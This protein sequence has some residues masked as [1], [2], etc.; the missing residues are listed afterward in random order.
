MKTWSLCTILFA[1]LM[2]GCAPDDSSNSPVGGETTSIYIYSKSPAPVDRYELEE[3]LQDFLGDDGM[4]S[5]G[6]AGDTGWNIDLE[7]ESASAEDVIQRLI[8]FLKEKQV[9]SD[10]HLDVFPPDWKEGD[11]KRRVNVFDVGG[12]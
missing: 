3:D 8:P 12:E 10:T 1:A 11:E 9:G 6:G 2:V 5:G 4:V 7:V